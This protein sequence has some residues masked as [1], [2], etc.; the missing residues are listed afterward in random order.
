[1][2]PI[3]RKTH[4][5]AAPIAHNANTT[6]LSAAAP[7]TNLAPTSLHASRSTSPPSDSDTATVNAAPNRIASTCTLFRKPR[8]TEDEPKLAAVRLRNPYRVG[9]DRHQI[10]RART[11]QLARDRVRE[12]PFACLFAKEVAEDRPVQTEGE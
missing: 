7:T 1:M 10:Y 11:Q 2:S 3:N 5:Y 8:A 12:M 4:Q 6:Q 9:I